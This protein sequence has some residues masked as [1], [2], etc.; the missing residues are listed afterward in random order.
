[1]CK[2]KL[3]TVYMQSYNQESIISTALDSVL[4]QKVSFEYE[5]LIVDDCSIDGTVEMIQKYLERYPDKIKLIRNEK[6][7]GISLSSSIR[8]YKLIKTKYWT[9]LDPDDYWIGATKMQYAIE[10]LETH[11]NFTLYATNVYL[12]D[13]IKK[14]PMFGEKTRDYDFYSNDISYIAHTSGTFFRNVFTEKEIDELKKYVGTEFENCFLGDSF[15]NLYHLKRGKAH[16]DN[17]ITSIYN[18]SSLGV[19][20]SLSSLKRSVENLKFFYMMFF[21]FKQERKEMF[22]SICWHFLKFLFCDYAKKDVLNSICINSLF[23]IFKQCIQYR[24]K[25]KVTTYG[26]E[27]YKDCYFYLPSYIGGVCEKLFVN[28]AKYLVDVLNFNVNYIDYTDGFAAAKLQG[29]K[30]KIV[31]YNDDV[32]TMKE[33]AWEPFN[34]IAPVT[35]VLDI[36]KFKHPSARVILFCSD[37]NTMSKLF[38]K[39]ISNT[40]SN[41]FVNLPSEKM[42]LKYLNYES[43]SNIVQ[44]SLD[45]MNFLLNKMFEHN[46]KDMIEQNKKYEDILYH[47]MKFVLCN[48]IDVASFIKAGL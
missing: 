20:S 40:N 21:Y 38:L 41:C 12:D 16:Y 18:F 6:N 31:L 10:F 25:S 2:N 29:S 36:S 23:K 9:I 43:N 34:I 19:Y 11:P 44:R 42:I 3:V 30:V 35:K 28:F 5:I 27:M 48:T 32:F 45:E 33:Q 46:E 13:G 8:A 22:L 1:M 7:L 4:A 26:F 15:R 17:R 14:K 47:F 37:L 39:K 24:N